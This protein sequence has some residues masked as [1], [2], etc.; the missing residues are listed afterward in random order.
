MGSWLLANPS[1]YAFSTS[2]I[3]ATFKRP[4]TKPC[5]CNQPLNTEAGFMH[6][7]RTWAELSDRQYFELDMLKAEHESECCCVDYLNLTGTISNL[8]IMLLSYDEPL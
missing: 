5:V 8:Y 6:H 7:F 2:Y 3:Q 1:G 4:W